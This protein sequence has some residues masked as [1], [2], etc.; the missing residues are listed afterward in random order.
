M[1][2]PAG[3]LLVAAVGFGLLLPACR[4]PE[5]PTVEP[6]A[7]FSKRVEEYVVLRNRLADSAGP[8]DETKS[9]AEPGRKAGKPRPKSI[10]PTGFPISRPR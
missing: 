5:N 3:L 2:Y 6:L 10:E 8:I 7:D 9:Q 1:R 4:K